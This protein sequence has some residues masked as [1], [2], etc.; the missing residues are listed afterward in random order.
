MRK[1]ICP[2]ATRCFCRVAALGLLFIVPC[3]S[4]AY[5][6]NYRFNN[7]P[8]DNTGGL[9]Y[10]NQRY[11]SSSVGR[12]NQP[13]PLANYLVTPLFRSRTGME[14]EDVLSNPQRLNSYSYS[15]N[16]PVNVTDPAG[17][18]PV[19]SESRRKRFNA[20]SDYIR[21]DENYWLVR[22]RDGNEAALDL[23][24]QKALD[25][26]KNK[27]GQ[28]DLSKALDSFFDSLNINWRDSKTLDESKDDYLDRLNNLPSNLVGFYGGSNNGIDKLQHFAAAARLSSRYGQRLTR[29]LGVF[30]EVRDGLAALF[31]KNRGYGDIKKADEGFS[32]GDLSANNLGI[33]WLKEYQRA[34]VFPS[35]VLRGFFR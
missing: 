6:T 17:E 5:S 24:W 27:K 26:S 29:W 33:F 14:L 35:V 12:F 3:V 21:N 11:Y 28:M 34:S 1:A 9:Y 32:R 25:L 20:L 10:F 31:N 13:D 2:A 16:N 4:L 30:K 8:F 18:A 23:I 7:K 19:V 22:D 15:L